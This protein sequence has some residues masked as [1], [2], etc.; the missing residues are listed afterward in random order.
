LA[1]FLQATL[2]S[3]IAGNIGLSK[4]IGGLLTNEI[5]L[6]DP[7]GN[8]IKIEDA[9]DKVTLTKDENKKEVR[10]EIDNGSGQKIAFG[11]PLN[12]ITDRLAQEL[13]Y[14]NAEALITQLSK[15]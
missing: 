1:L 14:K 7:K 12:E 2:D 8:I 11:I 13:G 10:V 15:K 9:K 4:F 3:S 6:T 5:K